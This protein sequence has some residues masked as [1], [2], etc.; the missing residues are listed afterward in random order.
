[1]LAHLATTL[2]AIISGVSAHVFVFRIGEWDVASLSI[3]VFYFVAFLTGVLISNVQFRI[4]VVEVARFAGYHILG[5]YLS[6]VIYRAFLHRL[7]SYPG[8]FLARLSNF[9]ITARSIK[10]LHLFEEVQSLHREYGD[11][12]RLGKS[13]Q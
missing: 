7:S 8:P 5:L 4:T 10:R 12:V 6:M 9:Y 3:F 2:V 13:I 1:M 11:Y